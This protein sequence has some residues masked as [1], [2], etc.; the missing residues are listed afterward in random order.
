M[1]EQ[2]EFARAIAERLERAGIPYMMTGSMAQAVYAT[3]RMTRDVDFVVQCSVGDVDRLVR[4][5]ETDCFVER[6]AVAEAVAARSMFSV[7]HREWI[8]KADLVVQKDD[9]YRR[10]EFDRR[11]VIQLA[12]APVT[13]V[14]PEDLILS[15]LKWAHEWNSEMQR[16]D[17]REL[18]AVGTT[19]DWAY[20]ERW[21]AHLGVTD[22]LHELHP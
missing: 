16:R 1:D 22:L 9:P 14:A 5:F 7:I 15:K 19:L 21:A 12:G 6:A 17:V 11:R 10:T 8:V 13:V 20:L 18:L 4:M 2:L 3:P